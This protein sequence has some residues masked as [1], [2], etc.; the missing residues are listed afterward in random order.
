MLDKRKIVSDYLSNGF[1]ITKNVL[2]SDI[3]VDF[4]KL[5][6]TDCILITKDINK[7][8]KPNECNW[9]ELDKN[10]VAL[11]KKRKSNSNIYIDNCQIE[12]NK[13]SIKIIKS[14]D[15]IIDKKIEV[16]DFVA[17]FNNRYDA[18]E[19]IL[20]NNKKLQES[21]SIS[22]V[23]SRR[24]KNL[25]AIIGFVTEKR[26]TKNGHLML[27]IEDKTGVIRVLI[28]KDRS[29]IFNEAKNLV[30]DE[31]IGIIGTNGDKI[32]FA[33]EILQPDLPI[34]DIK[35]SENESYALF[36]SDLH[37]G[38]K[39]FLDKEFN[40]FIDWINGKVGDSTQKEIASKI[41]YIFIVGD[42]VDGCGIY[43]GQENDLTIPDIYEQYNESAKLL[44]KIPNNIS[45]IICPGNHDAMRIAEPQPKFYEDFSK[46]LFKLSNVTLVSN[47]SMINI[48]STDKFSGFN[49]L[50]YHGYSFDYY[51]ANVEDI[52]NN[53]GYDS[54][55]SIMKFLL[56][57]RHLAPSHTSTLYLPDNNS[58]SLVIDKVPDFFITGHIHNA[59][60]A[61]F[62][63]GVNM[64]SCG[65][66]QAK[67]PFQEKIGHTPGPCRVPL[68]NLQTRKIKILRFG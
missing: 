56:K 62:Y 15:K 45:I 14:Y 55:D 11:E 25:A 47:P 58:D 51:V 61:A 42:I 35:K 40:K 6:P 9:I 57:R 19:K 39:Y 5:K 28:S 64:I 20:R 49:V 24:E 29:K 43:P 44:S 23:L 16:S 1:L 7:I 26:I 4:E 33:N 31:V 17:Y 50:M 60:V 59:P 13:P 32:I 18:L 30:L 67:T 2:D 46:A 41:K 53:G 63:R 68:I 37:I 54:A 10:R 8:N 48:D 38:S 52:R 34:K 36:L 27:Q 21:I 3:K 12:Q 66:W 22:R 65:C